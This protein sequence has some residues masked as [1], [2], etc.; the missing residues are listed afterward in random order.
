MKRNNVFFETVRPVYTNDLLRLGRSY[1]GGYV[2]N[3]RALHNAGLISFGINDDWSFER[4]FSLHSNQH[5]LMYDGS[6]SLEKFKRDYYY[7]LADTVSLRFLYAVIRN[8]TAAK[9]HAMHINNAKNLYLGFKDISGL[10]QANFY[11]LFVSSFSDA[12]HVTTEDVFAKTNEKLSYFMKIN[13]EGNEY[14]IL[15]TIQQHE[16]R[17]TGMVVE[18]HNVDIM[19]HEFRDYIQVLKQYF[20]ITHLHANNRSPVMPKFN[21]P[22]VWEIT[23]LNRRMM[24]ADAILMN[25]HHYPLSDM[26]FP[27]DCGKPEFRFSI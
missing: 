26:D 15:D 2:V 19:F 20:H 16:H 22:G 24:T 18:F 8:P 12:T 23:F 21:L 14:R 17:I 5:I 25:D 9:Q 27:N 13:I 1:D 7:A 11:S 6:V 4:D 10:K 3:Q